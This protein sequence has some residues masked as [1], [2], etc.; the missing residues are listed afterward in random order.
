MTTRIH[1]IKTWMS[2]TFLIEA[3]A[4]LVLVDTG[5]PRSEGRILARLHALG[6][7]D[8]RLIFLTHA[9]YDHFGSAAALKRL[10]GAPIAIH[11]IDADDLAQAQTTLGSVQG[12]A[13]LAKVGLPLLEAILPVTPVPADLLLDDG[14]RLD[15]FGLDAQIIHTPGH[16]LGSSTLLVENRLAFVGDLISMLGKPH[17][18][19]RFAVDWQL[20]AQSLHRLQQFQPQ[21]VYC[22]HGR[23]PLS[24]DIFRQLPSFQPR[25]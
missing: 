7:A 22:G 1:I 19:R 18:Q 8:L 10:T 23:Q 15:E 2:D 20:Q 13:W 21:E 5:P 14:D 4:G 12:I 16:T 3:E 9:H 17:A 24:G 11:R 25:L 6:R